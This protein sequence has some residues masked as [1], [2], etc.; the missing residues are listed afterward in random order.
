M[1]I[2]SHYLDIVWAGKVN[3]VTFSVYLTNLT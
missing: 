2:L 3:F 1:P